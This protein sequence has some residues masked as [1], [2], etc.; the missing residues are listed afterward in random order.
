[1]KGGLNKVGNCRL[2]DLA[3]GPDSSPG[4]SFGERYMTNRSIP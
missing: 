1:M 3:I 4:W 2:S